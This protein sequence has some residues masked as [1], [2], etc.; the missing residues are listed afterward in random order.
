MADK[1][2]KKQQ[3]QEHRKCY[4]KIRKVVVISE[5]NNK[6]LCGGKENGRKQLNGQPQ[7]YFFPQ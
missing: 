7:K 5:I 6:V 4:M 2:T 3:K 1:Q